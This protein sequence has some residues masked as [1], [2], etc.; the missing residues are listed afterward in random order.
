[1]PEKVVAV[2]ADPVFDPED[3][4]VA[5]AI[6]KARPSAK[7]DP[8]AIYPVNA[9][10]RAADDFGGGFRRLRSSREEAEAIAE[11][12]PADRSLKAVDFA[13]S[14][15]TALEGKLRDYRI[16]HFAT[17]GLINTRHPE[18][19]GLVLSLVDP[20]GNLQDGFLRLHD[21]YNLEL[22][23]D[24]VVLSSCRSALG[25][26]VRGEGLVGLTRGFM[27]AGASMVAASLWNVEDQATAELMKKF[28]SNMLGK[29]MRPARA[30]RAAQLELS[31]DA[32]WAAPYFWAGF[33][34]QG[35][36]R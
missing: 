29:G 27:F 22:N 36:W 28:Y 13:A 19:S 26:E 7:S 25:R 6:A 1:V 16:V 5:A 21:I 30:L 12:V 34:I 18:L 33:I 10:K 4:R 24:L 20:E 9:L 11:L 8:S 3:A 35:D 2:M 14:R 31:K 23:A 17:H 32:R 15:A